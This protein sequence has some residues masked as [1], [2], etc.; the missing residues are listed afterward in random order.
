MAGLGS[1]VQP[2]PCYSDT[3][4]DLPL[5]LHL[6]QCVS[7]GSLFTKLTPLPLSRLRNTWQ[8]LRVDVQLGPRFPGG[9]FFL[10]SFL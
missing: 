7:Q 5:H 6:R 3:N 2:L 4:S 10:R 1:S 9:R 8:F